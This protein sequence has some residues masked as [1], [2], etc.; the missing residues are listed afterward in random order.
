MLCGEYPFSRQGQ[1]C[2]G[3]TRKEER[4]KETIERVLDGRWS[5]PD[6]IMVSFQARSLLNCLLST[7]PKD[8]GFARGLLSMQPFLSSTHQ[9]PDAMHCSLNDKCSNLSEANSAHTVSIVSLPYI[10]HKTHI[11][12]QGFKT[13]YSKSPACLKESEFSKCENHLLEPIPYLRYIFPGRY[14]WKETSKSGVQLFFEMFVLPKLLGVVIQCQRISNRSNMTGVWMYLA[15]SGS[16]VCVGKLTM[17]ALPKFTCRSHLE[18]LALDSSSVQLINDAFTRRPR[19][20]KCHPIVVE[21]NYAGY[22]QTWNTT[23]SYSMNSSSLQS[24][25]CSTPS[26]I[27]CS[28]Q[29]LAESMYR[30]KK[31]YKPLATLLAKKNDS[32]LTIYRLMKT[33]LNKIDRIHSSF[34]MRIHVF[35]NSQRGSH[36]CSVT[37]ASLNNTKY[38]ILNFEDSLEIRYSPSKESG[39]LRG[40]VDNNLESRIED[41]HFDLENQRLALASS[42]KSQQYFFHLQFAH[43]AIKK[44]FEYFESNFLLANKMPINVEARGSSSNEWHI[45]S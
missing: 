26:S 43:E 20:Y 29:T 16:H 15:G 45:V 33:Y 38:F 23:K 8:R 3:D 2:S 35:A 12:Q 39:E 22:D 25:I 18:N 6:G 40:F 30:T 27:A 17:E 1:N 42:Q 11:F 10:R 31:L 9:L 5:I 19:K 44:C 7:N 14:A 34:F 37:T 4:I 28:Q 32:T 41:I 13:F 36:I 24:T 21:Q